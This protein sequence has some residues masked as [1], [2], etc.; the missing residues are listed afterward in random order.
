MLEPSS[1]VEHVVAEGKNFSIACLPPPGF[2]A[3]VVTWRNQL[4]EIISNNT[5]AR[6]KVDGYNLEIDYAKKP[7]GGSYI[8]RAQNL[9]GFIESSFSLTVAGMYTIE[10]LNE[11]FLLV[12]VLRARRL[13]SVRYWENFRG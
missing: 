6:V 13:Y 10:K 9:A 12:L 3:P 1:A 11:A 7:D 2:P 4:D 5:D 8:C